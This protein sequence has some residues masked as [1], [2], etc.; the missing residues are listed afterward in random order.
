[1]RQ[2][3]QKNPAPKGLKV[4]LNTFFFKNYRCCVLSRVA[5]F[6][7]CR[8]SYIITNLKKLKRTWR[9]QEDSGEFKGLPWGMHMSIITSQGVSWNSMQSQGRFRGFQRCLGGFGG[10]PGDSMGDAGVLGS[11]AFQEIPGIL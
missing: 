6:V 8:G 3:R 1:M 11:L 10:I 4:N 7:H 5:F 2:Q 9:Y